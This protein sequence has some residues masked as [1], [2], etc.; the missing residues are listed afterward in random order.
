ML[1]SEIV[2]ILANKLSKWLIFPILS[3]T[4]TAINKF[5]IF[6]GTKNHSHLNNNEYEIS[7]PNYSWDN[8][9]QNQRD[10]AEDIYTSLNDFLSCQKLDNISEGKWKIVDLKSLTS[11]V[12]S[13]GVYKEI[14]LSS[15]PASNPTPSVFIC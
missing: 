2:N 11:T 7:Y 1:K 6:L 15:N 13:V 9:D 14:S 10:S 12:V 8:L 5:N 4:S 3:F